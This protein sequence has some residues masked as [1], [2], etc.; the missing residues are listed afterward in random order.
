M[1]GLVAP[2]NSTRHDSRTFALN[3]LMADGHVKSLM[4]EQVSGGANAV[5]VKALP[6]GHTIKTFAVK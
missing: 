6:Q 1:I 2:Q 5:S 3:F 4:P